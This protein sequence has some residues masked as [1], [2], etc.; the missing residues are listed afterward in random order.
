M[1]FNLNTS[2]KPEVELNRKLINETISMYGIPVK[3]LYSE[4]INKDQVFKDFSHNKIPEDGYK[5]V[6]IM[7]E[8]PEDWEGDTVYNN[9]GFYNQWTQNLF[10]SRETVLELYPNFDE[11]GRSTLV[12]SLIIMPSS[13]VLEIT[14]V[15]TYNVGINN[16]W[17]F[18]DETSV[19]KLVVKTYDYNIA[20][21]GMADVKDS[22]KLDEDEIF[23]HNEEIDTALIDDFFKD[24][25]RQADNIDDISDGST[26]VPGLNPN[27]TDSVFGDLS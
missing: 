13:T 5:E 26:E 25:S 12:N 7:P 16:L 6:Y 21:E 18:A 27:N 2:R 23:E 17:G 19:Y 1:A 11:L 3:Y 8:N 24:L 10:I 20:D 15:E 4:K 14:H 9:F 22:I